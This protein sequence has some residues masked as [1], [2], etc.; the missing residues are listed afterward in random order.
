VD[1][2]FELLRGYARSRNLKFADV[3]RR[4]VTEPDTLPGLLTR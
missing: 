1:D 4:V 3:A 2:A